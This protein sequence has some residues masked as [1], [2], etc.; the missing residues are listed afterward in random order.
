MSPMPHRLR[1]SWASSIVALAVGSALDSSA[2]S[3][4][5]LARRIMEAPPGEARQE[6]EELYARFARR[7]RS[8]GRRHLR[9]DEAA[10]DLMQR[11]LVLTLEKLRGGAVREPDRI[12][13][14]ILGTARMMA[15]DMGRR[16]K[17][18]QPVESELDQIAAEAAPLP[19]PLAR[20]NLARCIEQLGERERSIILLTFF[21]EQDAGEIADALSVSKGNVRVIRH[22]A[23]ERLRK[24][25]GHDEEGQS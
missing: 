13:S 16:T 19:E 22:R 6:E 7:V 3:D 23:V 1:S 12:A 25:M 17:R 10:Q 2:V 21:Q 11:V 15:R 18:E 4:G 24:C 9:D 8:Y 20:A 5:V 14:F